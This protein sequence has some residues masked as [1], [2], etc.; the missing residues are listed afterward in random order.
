MAKFGKQLAIIKKIK[1]LVQKT[2]RTIFRTKADYF[3]SE[4]VARKIQKTAYELS[5]QKHKE[6][7][8]PPY[9]FIAE[10]LQV[11]NDQIF[12]AAVYSLAIIAQNET[13]NA[14][15]IISL[16]NK[17]IKEHDRTPE[18]IEYVNSKIKEIQSHA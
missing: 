12:R 2:S 7:K 9:I 1:S 3:I 14:S 13:Q 15:D 5:H 4:D 16:L 17:N 10:Q 8:T 6:N 18:Q 11:D